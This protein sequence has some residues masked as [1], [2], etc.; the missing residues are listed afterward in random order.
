MVVWCCRGPQR[1]AA[2]Q[3]RTRVPPAQRGERRSGSPRGRL[4]ADAVAISLHVGRPLTRRRVSALPAERRNRS[5]LAGGCRRVTERFHTA[6]D[7]VTGSVSTAHEDPGPVGGTGTGRTGCRKAEVLADPPQGPLQP[8]P[9]VVNRCG[10]PHP[11]ASTLKTAPCLPRGRAFSLPAPP[12]PPTPRG[13][14]P[15]RR[16]TGG[17]H[18]PLVG[19]RHLGRERRG[20]RDGAPGPG[21]RA[22][23]V[24]V[25]G[26]GA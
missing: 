11:G 10:R 4:S 23:P 24:V 19:H 2:S 18:R 6:T 17:P 26:R 21:G 16:T 9:P 1:T 22:R 3:G 5:R 13:T 7:R 15:G 25:M 8:G 12:G 14:G 20:D